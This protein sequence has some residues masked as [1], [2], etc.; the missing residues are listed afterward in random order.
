MRIDEMDVKGTVSHVCKGKTAEEGETM[1]GE[2][3]LKT[4]FAAGPAFLDRYL[5]AV[6]EAVGLMAS[7]AFFRT[8]DGKDGA[9]SKGSY[10]RFPW[11][12]QMKLTVT[13][14]MKYFVKIVDIDENPFLPEITFDECELRSL[15]VDLSANTVNVE[16]TFRF[17]RLDEAECATLAS[18]LTAYG[19]QKV[20]G[21]RVWSPQKDLVSQA[22][23][24][25]R[26][27]ETREA[28]EESEKP[29]DATQDELYDKAIDVVVEDRKTG[30]EHLQL[31]LKIGA[32]RAKRLLA[33][34]ETAGIIGPRGA[35]GQRD[36]M[37]RPDAQDSAPA[38]SS[39]EGETEIPE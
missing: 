9:M 25:P 34:M 37:G 39:Q 33:A 31:K 30:V 32:T 14:Q 19:L 4:R 20:V 10:V 17:V 3:L 24:S 5:H 15:K 29:V 16:A 21:I 36:I 7:G 28:R 23:E 8:F 27:Q 2:F 13:D 1:K 35:D 18:Q 38:V 22:N 11:I 6:S 12:E 26:A